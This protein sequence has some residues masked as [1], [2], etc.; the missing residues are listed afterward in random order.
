MGSG[1]TDNQRQR[2][3]RILR[4]GEHTNREVASMFGTTEETIGYIA[5][6]NGIKPRRR[7]W[8]QEENEII[9]EEYEMQG[10]RKLAIRLGRNYSSL[11]HHA[12]DMGLSTRV[13]AY[14]KLRREPD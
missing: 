3:V 8:T 14:G 11:C 1:L 4:R 2:I 5:R 13:S 9:R 10:P 6:K 12:R 7:P